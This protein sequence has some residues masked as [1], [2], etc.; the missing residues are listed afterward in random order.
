MTT[1]RP[2]DIRTD[3]W[4]TMSASELSQ[5]RDII[6]E[7]LSLLYSVAH[8]GTMPAARDIYLALSHALDDVN[9]LIENHTK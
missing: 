8:S 7:R 9:A 5:Q 3:L 4:N 6:N 1:E 2:A